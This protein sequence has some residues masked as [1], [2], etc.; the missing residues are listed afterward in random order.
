MCGLATSSTSPAAR[1]ARRAAAASA[2][3]TSE[4][5]RQD[6]R[7]WCRSTR[8]S[9]LRRHVGP[10]DRGHGRRPARDA[11]RGQSSA[12]RP[13]SSRTW[14]TSSSAGRAGGDAGRRPG[15]P[16]RRRAAS[17]RTCRRRSTRPAR[18][19]RPSSSSPA[20]AAWSA[21][22]SPACATPNGNDVLADIE[23][24]RLALPRRV[25]TLSQVKYVDRP[26]E[27]ALREPRAGR[28]PASSTTEPAVLRFFLGR[29]EPVTPWPAKLVAK[30]R[31]DFGDSL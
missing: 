13:R 11:R 28:R 29:L 21:A 30:F 3:T 2:P 10:R 25:F 18:W 5:Y 4:L 7:T 17:C 27:L 31:K 23:L 20:C 8:A 26:P 6:A 24:L 1:S 12:S 19:P 16:H 15:L 22:R 9:Y 14:S